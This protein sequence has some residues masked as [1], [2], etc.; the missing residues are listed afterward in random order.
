MIILLNHITAKQK[1]KKNNKKIMI[2]LHDK[3]TRE[4]P[5]NGFVLLNECGR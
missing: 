5:S 4:I 1:L 2:H 3:A